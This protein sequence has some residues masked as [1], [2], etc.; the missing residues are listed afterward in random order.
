MEGRKQL[1]ARALKFSERGLR[2]DTPEREGHPHEETYLNGRQ[3][4]ETAE[5]P[6]LADSAGVPHFG[7]ERRERPAHCRE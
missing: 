5:R 2:R 7:E 1:A 3:H 4:D 6:L